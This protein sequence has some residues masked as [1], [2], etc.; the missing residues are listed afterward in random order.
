MAS[1]I[2]ARSKIEQI[3]LEFFAK[4]L[5]IILES[6]IPEI[7]FG[8]DGSVGSSVCS[9]SSGPKTR[10]RWFNLALGDCTS[11]LENFVPLCRSFSDPMVVDVLLVQPKAVNGNIPPPAAVPSSQRS[12]NVGSPLKRV[13][14]GS[15]S[16]GEGTI[17]ERWIVQFEQR[18]GNSGLA[19]KGSH[20]FKAGTGTGV[21]RALD[22]GMG[23]GE[24]QEKRAG[25]GSE[26]QRSNT[27]E[28]ICECTEKGGNMLPAYVTEVPAVYKRTV[29]MIRSLYSICRLLP[30]YRL[31]RLANT[32][33]QSCSFTLTYRVLSSPHLFEHEER[34][35][36]IYNFIPVETAYGSMRLSVAY[37]HTTAVS[38][39]EI[40]PPI[41]PR[42]I[43]D[44]VGSPTT[45]PL[46]IFPVELQS[47]PFS[48]ISKS[49]A[50]H[51]V[52]VPSSVPNSTSGLTSLGRCH[53]WGGVVDQMQPTLQPPSSPSYRMS[54]T[55]SPSYPFDKNPS[56]PYKSSPYSPYSRKSPTA[57]Y[58]FS[59]LNSPRSSA[60]CLSAGQPTRQRGLSPPS[61][62]ENCLSPP[63]SPSP[64]PSPPTSYSQ[65]RRAGKGLTWSSSAPVMIPNLSH[66]RVPKLL[67][68]DVQNRSSLP[69]PSPRM[70]KAEA[71][72][73]S[74]L[75]S[76]RCLAEVQSH[77]Q[78]SKSYESPL[79]HHMLHAY[80]GQQGQKN[81]G[82]P[83][84]TLLRGSSRAVLIDDPDADEGQQQQSSKMDS[85][86]LKGTLQWGLPDAAVGAL[87][88]ML[89]FAPPLRQANFPAAVTPDDSMTFIDTW[90]REPRSES[91][92]YCFISNMTQGMQFAA[93]EPEAGALTEN[94]ARTA[95][96]AL[97]ELQTYKTMRDLLL[98]PTG[99]AKGSPS[100][101][102]GG[103]IR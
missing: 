38:A 99:K 13:T 24:L 54:R 74:S 42:I 26:L 69:P 9:S 22:A 101:R 17:L 86:R 23:S 35:M 4:S 68:G 94:L 25:S 78:R 45:D 21:S 28:E 102:A 57:D 75:E 32:S 97:D 47:L 12:A 60:D 73:R 93:L 80:D 44:Y 90:E 43:P 88:R 46:K 77:T 92:P 50:L 39:M 19:S 82:S 84:I 31:F 53:S 1:S 56:A 6:R 79:Q 98:S 72:L 59:P 55:P 91:P 48:G 85:L 70:R 5:H 37:R 11:D 67:M 7:C 103:N 61:S 16:I 41:L 96:D 29:I 87:Q 3:V 15:S 76:P 34:D 27:F 52:S 18:K 36:S 66:S 62:I 89:K 40:V 83:E 2:P 64:S 51:M 14:E 33:S 71:L 58:I 8:Q 100:G 10:D 81:E 20:S 63:F 95:S 65:D 30:A 49:R